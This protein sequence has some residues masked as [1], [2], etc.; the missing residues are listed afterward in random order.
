MDE[1]APVA[2]TSASLAKKQKKRKAD[3]E[4]ASTAAGTEAADGA[5]GDEVDEEV[6]E[7]ERKRRKAERKAAKAAAKAAAADGSAPAVADAGADGDEQPC[8]NLFLCC[9]PRIEDSRTGKRR[10]RSGTPR[11]RRR[12]GGRLLVFAHVHASLAGLADRTAACTA[13][14]RS[15]STS[16]PAASA[17]RRYTTVGACAIDQLGTR[18][19]RAFGAHDKVDGT[20][21]QY[22]DCPAHLLSGCEAVSEVGRRASPSH[23]RLGSVWTT[24]RPMSAPPCV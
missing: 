2:S 8:V 15:P 3:A 14:A 22:G 12:E 13:R 5:D 20:Q 6:D 16:S 1:D 18:Q 23:L 21:C 17:P 4:P 7:A 19:R 10:R 9:E 24:K 11:P